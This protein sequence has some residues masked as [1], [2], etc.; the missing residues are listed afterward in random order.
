MCNERKFASKAEPPIENRIYFG[1]LTPQIKAVKIFSLTTSIGGVIAQP[2]LY[3]QGSKL[4][5]MPMVVFI[6]TFAGFFTFVTPFLLHWVTRKY[7]TEMFYDP[8]TDEY[9]ATI[10]TLFLQKKYVSL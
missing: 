1:T 3:E 2:I 4:G 8:K 6:C 9:C 7:V 5:G 10:I